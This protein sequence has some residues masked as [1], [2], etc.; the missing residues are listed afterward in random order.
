MEPVYLSLNLF[1]RQTEV[2]EIAYPDPHES[3]VDRLMADYSRTHGQPLSRSRAEDEAMDFVPLSW[4]PQGEPD[5]M[6]IFTKL[7]R[8]ARFADLET[9]FG[10]DVHDER[11]PIWVTITYEGGDSDGSV[12]PL[13]WPIRAIYWVTA[14]GLRL[15]DAEVFKDQREGVARWRNTGVI[16]SH[17]ISLVRQ[18]GVY[19]DAEAFARQYGVSDAERGELLRASGY[20]WQFVLGP[21]KHYW[22]DTQADG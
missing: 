19:W 9:V 14:Q 12:V 20:E 1:R 11:G 21:D 3:V 8:S 10:P 4:R 2:Y 13:P 16:D 15:R 17:L 6:S 7:P 18:K 22:V 5:G